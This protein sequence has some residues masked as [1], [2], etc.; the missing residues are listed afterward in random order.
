LFLAEQSKSPQPEPL[1]DFE[2]AS[3]LS[4]F[5][6]N[7]PPDQR[8]LNLASASRLRESLPG[9]TERMIADRRFERSMSQFTDEWLDLARFDVVDIDYEKYPRMTPHIRAQLR[10]EP[11]KF[12]QYLVRENL[13]LS[14]LVRSEFIVANETTAAYYELGTNVESGPE[15][16]AVSHRKSGLGG[17]LT[18]AGILAGLSNGREANPVKRGAW[19]ARRIIAEPPPDPPPNVPELAGDQS[20][21]SLRERLE[22]HRNQE[23]CAGC[24][25]KIDPWGLPF[26]QY[27]AGGLLRS[28]TVV[29][30]SILP[31]ATEVANAME[32]RNYLA[33]ERMDQVA[34]SFLKH[35]A[36][37]AIGRRLTWNEIEFLRNDTV[38]SEAGNYAARD[39]IQFLISSDI[40]LMK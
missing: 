32:L 37:Y 40:F 17:V 25:A 29:A 16:V 20:E 23:G 15:Y 36:S 3:K 13:P 27:D 6:W 14:N 21:M 5:L 33:D 22:Q 38:E 8:L 34:F 1:S 7:S 28:E 11:A 39:L 4:Y 26:E 10:K 30:G 19:L 31:D 35:L 2:L 18:Q 9:E 12:V 24:H